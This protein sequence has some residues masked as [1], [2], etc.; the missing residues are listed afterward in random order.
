[1]PG[2]PGIAEPGAGV[3]ERVIGAATPGAVGVL[4]GADQVRLPL[5]PKLLL[6]P[7]RA[8][9]CAATSERLIPSST[10]QAR[11]PNRRDHLFDIIRL[12]PLPVH[13]LIWKARG[14]FKA[15][16]AR[17]QGIIPC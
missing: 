6:R 8:S 16:A 14:G 17:G 1:M 13:T 5:L 10:A 7:A 15:L 9:A 3:M 11:L 12:H 4:G 2:A